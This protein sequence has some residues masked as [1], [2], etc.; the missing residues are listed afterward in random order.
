M[1]RI[2]KNNLFMMRYILKFCPSHFFVIALTAI[3]ASATTVINILY[4]RFL[5]DA[6]DLQYGISSIIQFTVLFLIWNIFALITNLVTQQIVIPQNT[7]KLHKYMQQEIFDKTVELDYI[8]YENADFYQKYSIAL[9]QSDTRVLAVL[10]SFST[11]FGSILGVTTLSVL[12]TTIEPVIFLIVAV[13]VGI[14]FIVNL[15]YSKLQHKSYEEKVFPQRECGYVQRIF[16]LK[17]FAQELH[18]YDFL[19]TILKDKFCSSSNKLQDLITLYGIKSIKFLSISGITNVVA[20]SLSIFYLAI[21]ATQGL[22]SI[23]DF[24]AG[25]SSCQ[26][27][28]SQVLQLLNVFPQLYEHSLYIENFKEFMNISPSIKSGTLLVPDIDNL[29]L[30]I[31]NLN[32]QYAPEAPKTLDDISLTIYGGQKIAL[33]GENG[34]GKSTLIKLISRLYQPSEGQILLNGK[35]ISDYNISSYRHTVSIVFQDFQMFAFSIA[36]N[37]LLRRVE[38]KK[39]EELVIC[40]LKNVGLYDKVQALP[41]GIN[42]MFSREFTNSGAFFSG[43]ELQ[44]LAIARAYAQNSNIIILDEPTSGLDPFSE[45]TLLQGLLDPSNKKTVIL[46]SHRLCNIVN[47]DIICFFENGRLLEIGSHNELMKL[48]GK[49]AEMFNLQA[50]EYLETNM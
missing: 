41:N 5:V 25:A 37:I 34:A 19:Q 1:G 29:T 2:I 44:R 40:A 23:G 39:D 30:E 43:G 22:L 16:Y 13:N 45:N 9:Q 12:I 50:K 15:L 11:L 7:Q 27:L 21:R 14:T 28:T 47:M 42:T 6:I 31:R 20:N 3:L 46:S 4:L 49:Y 10:N 18:F 48:N 8:N 26:K 32:F 35:D 33:V 24:T 38:D 36:E 17:E